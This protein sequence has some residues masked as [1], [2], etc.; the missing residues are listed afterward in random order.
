MLIEEVV[1]I[2]EFRCDV[3][4]GES[5]RV[6]GISFICKIK[7][8]DEMVNS[9]CSKKWFNVTLFIKI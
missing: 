7:V 4:F 2:A 8:F 1:D 9:Y 6:G 3:E 5:F